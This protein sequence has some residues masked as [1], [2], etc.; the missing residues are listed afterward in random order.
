VATITTFCLAGASPK[1]RLDNDHLGGELFR[2]P[3]QRRDIVYSNKFVAQSNFDDGRAKLKAALLES[4]G[5]VA[6]LGQSLGARIA[7][8]LMDD[9][10]VLAAC[11]PERCVFVLTGH[12]ER[13]YGGAATVERSGIVSGYSYTGVPDDC[14]YRV[15]DVARQYGAPEDY[16]ADRSVRAAVSNVSLAVHSDYTNVRIGDPRNTA[17]VDPENPN[18]TYVLAPTYPL[19]GIESKWWSLQRKADEDARQRPAIEAAYD[20]PFPAPSTTIN[21]I[22]GTDYGYDGARRGFVLMPAPAAFRPFG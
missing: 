4:R 1:P 8:S 21:R 13:K 11:P 14:A 16:P 19:P 15:W 17:W 20:R 22:W 10:E 2:P 3:Y 7:G 18:V 12:P 9:A 6:V 5:Q